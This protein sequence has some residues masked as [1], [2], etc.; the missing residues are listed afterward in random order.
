[1]K[2]K[3]TTKFTISLLSIF[4]LLFIFCFNLQAQDIAETITISKAEK[5]QVVDSIALFMT[6][7]YVFPDKGKE[8]G[9]LVTKNLKGWKIR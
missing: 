7:R 4:F 6:D 8:M 2:T 1:M 9:D 5:Q 3:N